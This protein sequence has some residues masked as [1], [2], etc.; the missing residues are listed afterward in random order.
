MI[1][2]RYYHYPSPIAIDR[3]NTRVL[4]AL[5][6][7]LARDYLG[8]FGSLAKTYTQGP[9]KKKLD[10]IVIVV[11]KSVVLLDNMISNNQV[12]KRDVQDLVDYVEEINQARDEFLQ[13]A[14]QNKSLDTKIQKISETTGISPGDLSVTKEIIEKGARVT[15]KRTKEGVAPF[16][17]RTMPGTLGLGG[18]LAGGA[19]TALLGPFAPIAFMAGTLAK[20]AWGVGKGLRG[21]L[22]D[23][24][25]EGLS[26]RLTPMSAALPT[27]AFNRLAG[28]RAQRPF[29]ANFSG[30]SQRRSKHPF[31]ANFGGISQR[32]P[33]STKRSKEEMVLPLTYFFDKKAHKAK[34]TKE[35]L[36]RFK[37]MEKKIGGKGVGGLSG[38]L[39]GLLPLIGTIAAF[40]V[41]IAAATVSIYEIVKAAKAFTDWW[42][43]KEGLAESKKAMEKASGLG[44]G[45]WGKHALEKGKTGTEQLGII[46][47]AT[48]EGKLSP[49]MSKKIKENMIL[50]NILP[51][52]VPELERDSS[53]VKAVTERL[54]G[55]TTKKNKLLEPMPTKIKDPFQSDRE[56][57]ETNKSM[58]GVQKAVE[59]VNETL[60]RQQGSG[61]RGAALGDPYGV[62][63][64]LLIPWSSGQLTVGRD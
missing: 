12:S 4:S 8:F 11:K 7:K 25:E 50:E 15:R 13:Q 19:A 51:K 5:S 40:G 23:R 1:R 46:D 21:K 26:R 30:I 54:R 39:T 27:S 33:F 41:G 64:P 49:L 47:K 18:E 20:G 44:Q 35:L 43:A 2:K 59:Q 42:N 37:S 58:L 56:K 63:D 10:S 31:A 9:Q 53:E 34:W 29:A 16:M 14:E 17:K 48:K 24:R 32:R 57:K 52:K 38:M 36:D 45:T 61:V 62:G 22:Q 6:T 28:A 60:S 55:G 3:F